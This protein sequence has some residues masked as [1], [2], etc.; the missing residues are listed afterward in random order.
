MSILPVATA[1]LSSLRCPTFG[2][3]FEAPSI[4]ALLSH[5]RLVRASDPNFSVTCGIKGCCTTF[6]TFTALYQQIYKKHKNAGIIKKRFAATNPVTGHAGG[7]SSSG[8]SNSS[9][10]KEQLADFEAEGI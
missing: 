8:T 10:P 7:I 3:N 6:K 9:V 5:L 4:P 2:C 1:D